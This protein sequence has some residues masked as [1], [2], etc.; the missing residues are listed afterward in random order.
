MRVLVF[1]VAPSDLA[2]VHPPRFTHIPI[3][4]DRL[5][6]TASYHNV[7][8]IVRVSVLARALAWWKRKV[9]DTDTVVLEQQLCANIFADFAHLRSSIC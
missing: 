7:E 9:P 8:V 2:V 6:F 3:R 5:K 4:V 1:D